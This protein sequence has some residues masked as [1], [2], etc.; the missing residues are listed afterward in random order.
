[1]TSEG[2]IERRYV[3]GNEY[4]DK[5][6]ALAKQRSIEAFNLDPEQWSVNVQPSSGENALYAALIAVLKPH[7]R[8]MGL[9][10]HDGGTIS[11]GH[12]TESKRVSF[13]SIYFETIPYHV[14]NDGYIDYD[15]MEKLALNLRPKLIIA[16]ASSYCRDWDYSRM[17]KIADKI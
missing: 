8:I 2:R 1:K 11:H 12:Y 4:I 6:E 15:Y 13:T 10:V 7:D 9:H 16:G 17:R 5:I 3:G 14:K